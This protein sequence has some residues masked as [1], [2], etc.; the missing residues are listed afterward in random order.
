M[1][2]DRLSPGAERDA[3]ILHALRDEHDLPSLDHAYALALF[4]TCT[5][6][7]GDTVSTVTPLSGDGVCVTL[8]TPTQELVFAQY[9]CGDTCLL[10][11]RPRA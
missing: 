8:T 1:R 7:P 2:A 5:P 9:S 10:E 6:E 11:E 4:L 3:E